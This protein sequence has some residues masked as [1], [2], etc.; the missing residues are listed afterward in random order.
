MEADDGS[1]IG[2]KAIH[3]L[4]RF[5]LAATVPFLELAGQDLGIALNLIEVVVRELAP[6][7]ANLPLQLEPF[8]LE[9]IRVH[10]MP[11]TLAL[12]QQDRYRRDPGRFRAC[13]SPRVPGGH[14]KV[15]NVDCDRDGRLC[16][17]VRPGL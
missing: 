6:L 1:V 15:Q 9:R 7:A 14:R 17:P 8:S 2:E 13:G 5:F 3:F 10:V 16:W 4:P 11:P 12:R